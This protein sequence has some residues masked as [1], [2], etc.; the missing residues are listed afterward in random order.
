[1]NLTFSF[2]GHSLESLRLISLCC[3]A[4]HTLRV[5]DL[6]VGR[7]AAEGHSDLLETGVK[8]QLPSVADAAGVIGG[9]QVDF[10]RLHGFLH[11]LQNLQRRQENAENA[12]IMGHLH[13]GKRSL[14]LYI[15]DQ[16]PDNAAG[17]GVLSK[18]VTLNI[19]NK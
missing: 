4:S 3:S 2:Q 19:F 17:R 12:G 11:P 13:C 10:G 8:G 5:P 15:S 14:V 6:N 1:M 7:W 9:Q 18:E 16:E